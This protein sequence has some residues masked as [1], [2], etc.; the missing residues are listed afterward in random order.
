MKKLVAQLSASKYT[1][2]SISTIKNMEIHIFYPMWDREFFVLR[3][4]W[5]VRGEAHPHA[6]LAMDG[7][8]TGKMQAQKVSLRVYIGQSV[9]RHVCLSHYLSGTIYWHDSVWMWKPQPYH[10]CCWPYR[11]I[12]PLNKRWD[13]TVN[14]F[15]CLGNWIIFFLS[16]F[17]LL[18]IWETRKKKWSF[19]K[20]QSSKRLFTF[21]Y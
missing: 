6:A 14:I 3:W 19:T 8:M 9:H 7:E 16:S 5:I 1:I 2:S 17:Y 21:N 11:N 10:T 18:S 12:K 4:T 20:C 15:C 13:N